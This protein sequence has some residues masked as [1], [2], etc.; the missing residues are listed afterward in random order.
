LIAIGG[1]Q[2]RHLAALREAGVGG[3]AVISV[4]ATAPDPVA[5][6]RKLVAGF[7]GS[8]GAQT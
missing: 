3:L 5:T 2:S 7:A 6:T 1:I 4:V 8:E